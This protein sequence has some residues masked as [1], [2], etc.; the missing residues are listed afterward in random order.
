MLSL[1]VVIA[2]FHSRNNQHLKHVLQ[3]YQAIST[4]YNVTIEVHT[5]QPWTIEEQT[6]LFPMSIHSNH[7]RIDFVVFDESIALQLTCQ[8]RRRMQQ[9]VD[10]YDLFIYQED[11]LDIQHRHVRKF[12]Q[13]SDHIERVGLLESETVMEEDRD[14]FFPLVGFIRFE[15]LTKGNLRCVQCLCK[16]KILSHLTLIVYF[17]HFTHP[18]HASVVD[19]LP[20]ECYPSMHPTHT[21]KLTNISFTNDTTGFSGSSSDSSSSGTS[22]SANSNTIASTSSEGI[23]TTNGDMLNENGAGAEDLT[24]RYAIEIP[25]QFPLRLRCIAGISTLR[26]PQSH[27]TLSIQP[28]Y[29]PSFNTL[30][31]TL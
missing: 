22:D 27:L 8:H 19:L 26:C 2:S 9:V 29:H 17:S 12:H 4:S 1:F 7:Y 13:L 11:D 16:I 23:V 28:L 5:V 18:F 24:G 10:I 21:L 14:W 31:P 30:S 20:H 6:N 25:G 15:K 3:N